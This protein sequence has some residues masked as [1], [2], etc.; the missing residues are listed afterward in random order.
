MRY[1]LEPLFFDNVCFLV[2]SKSLQLVF[3]VLVLIS[4]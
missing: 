4:T 2:V 1:V 3:I